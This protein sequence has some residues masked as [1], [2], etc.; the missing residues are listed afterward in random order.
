MQLNRVVVQWDGPAVVGAA[1]NV[2]HFAGDVGPPDPSA[3]K[4]AYD[5]LSTILPGTSTIVTPSSGDVIEDT[6][7]ELLD[8]WSAPGGGTTVGGAGGT[9]AG[10]VG[11]CVTWL[12]G[13]IIN[14]RRL[15]GRTFLVPLSSTAYEGDGT[16]TTT[17]QTALQGFAEDLIASGPLAV[18]HRPTGPSVSD[19]NSY[20]VIAYRLRD[21]VAF[22]SSRRD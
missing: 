17:A 7:G 15:R 9:V 19:G 22:L 13:G 21:K 5:N 6:T 16:L 8:V 18:W 10:G 1:V 12:T 20:G 3:I 14:G 2:L 11:A 4:A